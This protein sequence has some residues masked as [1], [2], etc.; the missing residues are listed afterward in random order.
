[1]EKTQE[2][3]KTL[4]DTIHKLTDKIAKIKDNSVYDISVNG[5]NL[6][7]TMNSGRKVSVPLNVEAKDGVGI[8]NIQLDD[9]KNF[10]IELD[11][12]KVINL[13]QIAK[14][15]KDGAGIDDA[16]FI[17]N[18]IVLKLT[19]GRQIK[20]DEVVLPTPEKG[21]DGKEISTAKILGENLIIGFNDGSAIDAGKIVTTLNAEQN[22]KRVAEL[23]EELESAR[24]DLKITRIELEQRIENAKKLIPPELD[25][26]AIANGIYGDIESKLEQRLAQIQSQVEGINFRISRS[27]PFGTDTGG[28]FD[29]GG[30]RKFM[31]FKKR[32]VASSGGLLKIQ[33]KYGNTFDL[34]LT[35][36]INQVVFEAWP[37][38][39]ITQRVILY[40]NNQ[41]NK[42]ISGWPSNI[43]WPDGEIPLTSNAIDCWVFESFDNGQTIFGNQ[44]GYNYS[45]AT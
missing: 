44:A 13:G 7:A 36:D 26:E 16:L 21:K 31:G 15:G 20:L 30:I 1:M 5:K 45:P 24:E 17:E 8:H 43:L 25:Q 28:G 10:I 11:S 33:C 27:A 12:G 3:K 4:L 40:T 2:K 14:D 32:A 23:R 22:E 18:K 19:D 41:A 35:E 38:D 34:T 42:T 9:D 39:T 29:G 37:S 6:I